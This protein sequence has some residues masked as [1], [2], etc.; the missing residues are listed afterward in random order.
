MIE[1]HDN[2]QKATTQATENLDKLVIAHSSADLERKLKDKTL[3]KLSEVEG[4]ISSMKSNLQ[5]KNTSKTSIFETVSTIAEYDD[6]RK[7]SLDFD[8]LDP[9]SIKLIKAEE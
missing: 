6:I 4:I 8:K 1:Y 5:D 9:L 7:Q 2:F 3:S